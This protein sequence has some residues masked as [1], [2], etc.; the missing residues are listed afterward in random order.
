M[1]LLD[2]V[3]HEPLLKGHAILCSIISFQLR[4]FVATQLGNAKIAK[5]LTVFFSY[6]T[7]DVYIKLSA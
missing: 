2:F 6:L 4:L 3:V 1:K 7:A 5:K